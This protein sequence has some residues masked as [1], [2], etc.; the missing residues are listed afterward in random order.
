MGV[1]DRL[2]GVICLQAVPDGLGHVKGEMFENLLISGS[3][4]VISE[5]LQKK[6]NQPS[7]FCSTEIR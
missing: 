4:S 6:V 2:D 3:Y 1:F 7:P 5:D